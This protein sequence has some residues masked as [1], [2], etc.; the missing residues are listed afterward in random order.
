MRRPSTFR[1][2]AAEEPDA[3]HPDAAGGEA[4]TPLHELRGPS[5]SEL[6]RLPW[7]TFVTLL[8]T[9]PGRLRE[10]LEPLL[11]PVP[12]QGPPS[13]PAT[14]PRRAARE[15]PRPALKGIQPK[16]GTS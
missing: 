13:M 4:A 3:P 10:P 9:N 6:D 2:V 1:P 7:E 5:I 16:K 8:L 12:E 14:R 11:D 15:R